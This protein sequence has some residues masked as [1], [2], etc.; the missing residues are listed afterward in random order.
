MVRL[1]AGVYEMLDTAHTAYGRISPRRALTRC[2]AAGLAL[3]LAAQPVAAAPFPSAN[4][5]ETAQAKRMITAYKAWAKRWSVPNGSLAVMTGTALSGT[6]S[7]GNYKPVKIAPVASE[8]KAIT[9][10]C[11]AKLVDAK[12]LTFATELKTVLKSYFTKNRPAD[13]RIPAITIADLLTHSSGMTYDPSQG[14][15]I[16]QKLPF[17]ETNLEKQT[18]IAFETALGAK[19]GTE[20]FYNNMNYAVLG[21][22]IETI[23]N[24]KYE[25]YCGKTVLK[26]VGVTDAVLNPPWRI[27]ASWG[28]WKISAEDYAR[29]LEYFLPSKHLLKTTPAKWPQFSLGGGAYYSL[30]TLMRQN[31]TGYNFW[32]EGSWQWSGTPQASFGAYF[33]VITENVRYMAEYSP[34]ISDDAA[35]D[36]DSS[37]YAAATANSNAQGSV[38]GRRAL[39][40]H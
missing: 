32:H 17:T 13:K 11:I 23:T 22:V 12:K 30:G 37:M 19:P 6:A 21:F 3:A 38:R 29:F 9:A 1:K 26:P 18:K 16:E 40:T 27:M 34:T 35:T 8:S 20:Y 31:G 39:L 33:T 5:Q 14:G 10:V 15:P 28:G 2:A 4:P 7:F 25:N 36:L 24:Q